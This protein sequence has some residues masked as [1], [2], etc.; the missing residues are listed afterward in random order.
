MRRG[1][2][3]VRREARAAW[4][5]LAAARRRHDELT[6]DAAAE[7]ARLAELAALAESTE[8]L[9]PATEEELRAE[10]ELL[11]HVTELAEG[12]A[13]A[14]DALSPDDGDGAATLAAHAERAIAPL[15][16]L[17][18]ELARAGDEL[19]D[20]ELRLREV[21]SELRGFLASLEARPDRVEAV[22]SELDRI[23]EAKRR[24]RAGSYEELLERASS[25]RAELDALAGG[26]DPAAAAAE[27]LAEAEGRFAA[28]VEAL[29][30]ARAA[31]TDAFADA[32][33]AELR[34]V[35]MGEGEFRVELRERAAGATGANEAVFLIRP[36]TGLPW[37]PSPRR[38]R[39]ASSAR[40]ARDRGGRRR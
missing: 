7:E 30:A 16:R 38:P 13:A 1:A 19:R 5:E 23:A 10:R 24:F 17:A 35:G 40:R 26:L 4:R 3:R 28:L 11:R 6:R 33:A 8:G 22:E 31:A 25:A 32:V 18:P 29:R 39:G 2:V 27:A 12:A 15:E 20:L 34:G 21:G 37:D 36:N 9:E 14:A